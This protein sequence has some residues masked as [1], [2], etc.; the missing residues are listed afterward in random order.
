MNF[1][2][3]ELLVLDRLR[4]MDGMDGIMEGFANMMGVDT[5]TINKKEGYIYNR[6]TGKTKPLKKPIPRGFKII[7]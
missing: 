5:Y 7:K 4:K 6:R 1:S 3:K 2:I